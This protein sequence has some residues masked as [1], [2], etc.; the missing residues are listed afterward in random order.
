MPTPPLGQ[1]FHD[2]VTNRVLGFLLV[3]DLVLAGLHLLH[4]YAG[5][6][7][8]PALNLEMD[9]G[10]AEFFQYGKFLLCAILLA[11]CAL[12]RAPGGLLAWAAV[13]LYLLA[14][15]ALSLHENLGLRVSAAFDFEPLAGLRLRDYGELL[16]SAVAGTALLLPLVW[17]YR[18]GPERFKRLSQDLAL[19][20]GALVVLGV[21]LDM[22]QVAFRHS[23]GKPLN[24]LLRMLEDLGEMFVASTMVWYLCFMA[25]RGFDAPVYLR[26]WFVGRKNAVAK[27]T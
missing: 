19:L 10:W 20:L 21:G 1:S 12:G 3:G 27:P 14:D 26:D 7:D 5:L 9:Q 24:F 17:A 15:D 11:G 13:F 23:L 2:P 25:R 18:R 8:A 22:G 4:R 16:V 6:L